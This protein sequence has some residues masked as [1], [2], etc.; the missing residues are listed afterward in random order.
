MK[1]IFALCLL[2]IVGQPAFAQM[3]VEFVSN[4]SYE[5]LRLNDIWGYVAPDGTEYALV[6]EAKEG[7]QII[8]LANL[9]N[10]VTA[11][12]WET[13]LAGDVDTLNSCHNLYIDENGYCYLTGCNLIDGGFI[14]LDVFSEPGQP[15]VVGTGPPIYSHDIF[16]RNN[17][18]YSSEIREGAMTVY[19]VTDKANVQLL[20]S[21]PTPFQFTHN[22]WLS[23]DSFRLTRNKR[24]PSIYA[25]C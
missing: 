14:I 16:V 13:T 4:L 11:R 1:S 3:N 19:N 5:N 6:T 9:P 25:R 22:V 24:T 2:L 20:A 21:Q 12:I 18:A 10:Q 8:D 23:D 15:K 17:L 7:L